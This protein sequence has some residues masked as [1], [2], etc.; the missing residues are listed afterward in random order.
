MGS[1]W[2]HLL[3]K[4]EGQGLRKGLC[5]KQAPPVPRRKRVF[6]QTSGGYWDIGP[7]D[8][9]SEVLDNSPK[10]SSNCLLPTVPLITFNSQESPARG[11]NS[12]LFKCG[13]PYFL[14]TNQCFWNPCMGATTGDSL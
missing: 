4:L 2:G 11:K 5:E 13:L 6:C 9:V 12:F 3:D 1:S 14:P 8:V 10:V 7:W